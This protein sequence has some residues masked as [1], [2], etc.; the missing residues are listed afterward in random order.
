MNAAGQPAGDEMEG[1]KKG[2]HLVMSK[3]NVEVRKEQGDRRKEYGGLAG[4]P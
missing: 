1:R 2:L 4:L 3:A